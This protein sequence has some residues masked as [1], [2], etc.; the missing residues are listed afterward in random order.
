[1]KTFSNILFAASAFSLIIF[2]WIGFSA[3]AE[4]GDRASG[5]L[6]HSRVQARSMVKA[7]IEGLPNF[8]YIG[9][10][11]AFTVKIENPGNQPLEITISYIQGDSIDSRSASV[12][13]FGQIYEFFCVEPEL[14]ESSVIAGIEIQDPASNMVLWR[15]DFVLVNVLGD[16]SEIK[17]VN[18][19]FRDKSGKISVIVN[20]HENESRY[21]R[22]A[23]V[24]WAEKTWNLRGADIYIIGDC[25]PGSDF[26]QI[27]EQ[28]IPDRNLRFLDYNGDPLQG[29]LNVDK[30]LPAG[31]PIVAC[32]MWGFEESLERYPVRDFSQA[33]DAAVDRTRL[34]NPRSDVI[35]V[36]PPPLVGEAQAS[37]K[38]SAA[39]RIIAR[40]HHA[41]LID[42]HKKFLGHAEDLE[43][44]F[45]VQGDAA[46]SGRTPGAEGLEKLAG[47]L[48]R[49]I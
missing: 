6:L 11:R 46:V 48:A 33:L 40:D 13:P 2:C 15:E 28:M 30:Y 1:M 22:W 38:Y 37:E 14:T 7:G 9:E 39:M 35:I 25:G 12:E 26:S 45:F 23:P 27:L 43:G 5:L 10:R 49:E 47:W 3:R 44:F 42:A 31:E 29:L 19:S 16:L 34:L 8:I 32:F 4:E 24:K 21:R 36:T 20:E 18:R 41:P 17:V